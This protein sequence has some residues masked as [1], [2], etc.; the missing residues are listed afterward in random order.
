V[1]AQRL[2]E[3]RGCATLGV[4]IDFEAQLLAASSLPEP[5]LTLPASPLFA[6]EGARVDGVGVRDDG[7]ASGSKPFS[8]HR[9]EPSQAVV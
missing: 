8:L 4:P 1:F 2:G 7:H 5:D 3:C 6:P 9:H